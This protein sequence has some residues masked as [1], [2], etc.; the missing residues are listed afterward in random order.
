MH[1]APRDMGRGSSGEIGGV[2]TGERENRKA[3]ER[4]EDRRK[5]KEIESNSWT[6]QL[7]GAE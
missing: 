6:T 3:E 5:E 1:G 2:G 4:K 7:M